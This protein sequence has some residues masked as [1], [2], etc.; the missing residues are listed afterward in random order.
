MSALAIFRASNVFIPDS[1][2]PFW[3]ADGHWSDW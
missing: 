2:L 3:L 1:P